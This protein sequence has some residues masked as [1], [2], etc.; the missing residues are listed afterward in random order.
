MTGLPPRS[1]L[2]ELNGQD[3]VESLS[4]RDGTR[5]SWGRMK[6]YKQQIHFYRNRAIVHVQFFQTA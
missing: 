6:E 2:W 1:L 4:K 5:C 3:D